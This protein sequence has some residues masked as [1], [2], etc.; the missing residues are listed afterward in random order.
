MFRECGVR[1]SLRELHPASQLG[2]LPRSMWNMAVLTNLLCCLSEYHGDH[3]CKEK[4]WPPSIFEDTVVSV[5]SILELHVA[6]HKSQ[7]LFSSSCCSFRWP[8]MGHS[9]CSHHLTGASGGQ[10][11][12]TVPVLIILLELHVAS[13]ES[14]FLFSS[15]CCSF[16]WPVMSHSSCSPHLVVA[17]GGQS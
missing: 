17:S 12:V 1:N 6:S 13:H 4:I 5:I 3:N 8:V 2:D 16:R 9:S 10:S 11:W 7:F 14:Q 15:S